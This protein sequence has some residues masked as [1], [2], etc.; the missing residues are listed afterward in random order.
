[1]LNKTNN[2]VVVEWVAFNNN[3]ILNDMVKSS[4]QIEDFFALGVKCTLSIKD[5]H[6]IYSK[7]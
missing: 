7:D 1:M 3:I 5:I 6:P 2:K 4:M